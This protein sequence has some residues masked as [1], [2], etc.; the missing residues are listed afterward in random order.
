MLL[1]ILLILVLFIITWTYL[2]VEHFA[3]SRNLSHGWPYYW[4][5]NNL[6]DKSCGHH[7]DHF[8]KHKDWTSCNVIY[9]Q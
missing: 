8:N 9:V 3:C 1:E 6:P 2:G 5:I 4:K 7:Y